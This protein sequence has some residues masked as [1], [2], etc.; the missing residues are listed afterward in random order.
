MWCCRRV[1]SRQVLS[2]VKA[3]GDEAKPIW[4]LDPNS[5]SRNDDG[6]CD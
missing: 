1:N 2:V 5:G 6:G 3:F 4:V